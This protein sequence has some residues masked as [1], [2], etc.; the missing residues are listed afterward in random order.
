MGCRRRDGAGVQLGSSSDRI[1]GRILW[2][3][4]DLGERQADRRRGDRR[5]VQKER[6]GQR[7]SWTVK[8]E[9]LT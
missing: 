6:K 1:K 9:S 2:S 3:R 7:N 8:H 5:G 4:T